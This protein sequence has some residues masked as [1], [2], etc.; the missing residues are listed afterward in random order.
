MKE[1][2]RNNKHI[3]INL[4]SEMASNMRANRAVHSKHSKL[5]GLL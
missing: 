4:H 3:I 5:A 2:K 1:R